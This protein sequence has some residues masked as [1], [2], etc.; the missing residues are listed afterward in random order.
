MHHIL[1][2]STG[3]AG[4]GIPEDNGKSSQGFN[5]PS[6]SLPFG[7]HVPFHAISGPTYV[8]TQ[9]LIQQTAY[10]LSDR[11]FTYS[12]DTFDLDVAVRHW[13]S[14]GANNAH[15]YA[16]GVS[17]MQIRPGAGSI[18]LGYVYSRDFDPEKRHLPQSLISSS[19]CL[20]YLRATLSQL[21]T[22]H[23]VG[24]P[25]VAH[26]A[27]V[28][29]A[30]G[31][32]NSLV[33][34]YSAALPIAE[35]LGLGMVCSTS[36]H[37][38]QHMALFS[39]L[40]SNVLPTIHIY[41]G[42]TTGRQ[43]TR[44]V[45]V[46]NSKGLHAT[47]NSVLEEVNFSREKPESQERRLRR[48]LR[49]FNGELGTAYELFEYQ[50]HDSPEHVLVVFGTV[51]SSLSTSVAKK[52]A[53]VGRR[54]GVLN[55]RVYRPF[56]EEEFLAA[57][58]L[59]V[60]NVA[61]L[62]QVHS[63]QDVDDASIHSVLYEDILATINFSDRRTFIPSVVDVKY[64]RE[65][66]W[67]PAAIEAV[68]WGLGR[69]F[70]GIS[71]LFNESETQT[72]EVSQIS[73]STSLQQYIFW[74]VDESLSVNAPS[75]VGEFLA[76][77]SARNIS[78][79]TIHDD[80]IHGGVKR[81]DIRSSKKAVEFSA[82]V[83][84]A[85]VVYV[86]NLDL[87]KDINVVRSV[88]PGGVLL[89]HG[90]DIKDEDLEK[91]FSAIN[92]R[93]IAAKAIKLY[94]LNP[95]VS[96]S[97][98]NETNHYMYIT[99]LAFIR[100]ARPD[101]LE[102]GL[103]KVTK[104]N[105]EDTIA[106]R[107]LTSLGDCVREVPVPQLWAAIDVDQE[108]P[109]S[110]T[111]IKAT[112]FTKFHKQEPQH[113]SLLRTWHSMAKGI[114][115]K[116]AYG[117]KPALRPDLVAKTWTVHVKENRRLTPITYDRNIFHIE[118]DLGTSGLKY[119]IGEALGIH[120]EN[121]ETEVME[122]IK[123]YG[124]QPEEVVE[125]PSREDPDVL[126]TRT[127]YQSLMQNIDIFGRPPKKF[128]EALAEFADDENEKKEL[129]TLAGPEGATE[130]K[131]RAEVDT[132]TYADIL[133]EFPSAHP[134]F[135]DIVRIVSPLKRREY[136]IA[137]SQKVTPNSVALL[138]VTVGWVDPKGRDRFGQATR[139]LAK[140]KVGDL[141]TVSVKPSVMKLPAKATQPL[142]MAG[143]GTG[144]APFRAFVQYRAWQKA[145]GIDIGSVLLYMGSRHQREEYLYGEEWEA[146]QAAGV[147]TLLGR[148]FSRDQ[149]QKIYIQDRMRQTM[150]DIIQAYIK[151][152]GSFYLCGP[153]WPVPDVTEVLQEAI[154]L[155]AKAEGRK[156]DSRKEIERL[157][158]DLRY[159]LEGLSG[160][161]Y[162]RG[163]SLTVMQ[164][165]EEIFLV[166]FC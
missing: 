116:E 75:V 82:S 147:I 144:L 164:C 31:A 103:A 20:R 140:L 142:I 74:D 128:Y 87:F 137:S 154:S 2:E 112:S 25:I 141:V 121:D 135:H 6:S 110:P 146:Y 102:T 148:A 8:T 46:L 28:D 3:P 79:R 55:V 156:V 12:P 152:N 72:Q 83:E 32:S 1:P 33:S 35:E 4:P 124:L 15:G 34:D 125:V 60:R 143:L 81:T 40:L 29:Y 134:S 21:S 62:G 23:H 76:R 41:D 30:A 160:L 65:Q 86:G 49:A 58:P 22:L 56:V 162:H 14:Q 113:P 126:E 155:E 163:A 166:R 63:Q 50:G 108:K 59:S 118:F 70:T 38:S 9:V 7:R 120:G 24:N 109:A 150:S 98:N 119:E 136:S 96:A 37:E 17:P 94:I 117:T 159:V 111:D 100:V 157:K 107:I 92:K 13:S 89:V 97:E 64:A 104:V 130:F 16:T 139:Y 18:A 158:D 95:P 80:M 5:E 57:L 145:Q 114:A 85:D 93:T 27:A 52:L 122:F 39:T 51:E 151:D 36:A 99:V 161:L 45:D 69:K 19:S 77:D 54:V 11:I 132:I 127:V 53:K 48:L 131:R 101:L 138:V 61:V 129:L 105:G 10:T 42:V 66:T 106:E 149:R 115:F 153:T 165:I 73:D 44:V 43:T 84:E 91:N 78:M 68:F 88:K 90:P 67:T 26:V 123:F 47:Y 71:Q 133:L